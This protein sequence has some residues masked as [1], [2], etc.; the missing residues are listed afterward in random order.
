[1]RTL[2]DK[3]KNSPSAARVAPFAVFILLTACQGPSDEPSAYWLYLTKTLL[4]AGM[5]WF[6]W[7]TVT[8]M[9]WQVSWAAVAVGVAV[10]AVWV[11]LDGWYPKGK[12]VSGQ[13]NPH[14]QFGSGSATAWF[15][16]A[17]RLAGS[18]CFVPLLEEVFF[19]SWFYRV[20]ADREFLKVP[21]GQFQWTSFVATSVIFGVQH[22][23]WLAG[24]LCGFAY[25]GLVVWK[26]RLG[27]AITA[28][29]ITNL[30][31]GLWVVWRGAWQFW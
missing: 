10:F 3:L 24:I 25:Q 21:L 7:P 16:I 26:K 28:H 4:G 29:A 31:L 22:Q 2:L 19:R 12:W 8:E 11:G 27:D 20:L 18:T 6:V 17:V 1:M 14:A 15:F 5:I 30:L 9:R 13:W 23:E